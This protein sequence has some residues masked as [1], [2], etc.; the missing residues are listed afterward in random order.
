MC[1]VA[2]NLVSFNTRQ[3]I[4]RS[5]GRA[6]NVGYDAE[7]V[8]LEWIDDVPGFPNHE[9]TLLENLTDSSKHVK[10]KLDEKEK[11]VI[12]IISQW[13]RFFIW[14]TELFLVHSQRIPEFLKVSFLPDEIVNEWKLRQD[15][16]NHIPVKQPSGIGRLWNRFE[17]FSHVGFR[18]EQLVCGL[19]SPVGNPITK[20]LV[21]ENPPWIQKISGDKVEAM[22]HAPDR[23]K[24]VE[25]DVG[26]RA[27]L[28]D[29]LFQCRCHSTQSS[30]HISSSVG[31][32]WYKLFKLHS[33]FKKL[34][35]HQLGDSVSC[36]GAQNF[37][38]QR[39][40]DNSVFKRE[41][42][43]T[44]EQVLAPYQRGVNCN[45]I[46]TTI[47]HIALTHLFS[48][49]FVS[50]CLPHAWIVTCLDLFC[51]CHTWLVNKHHHCFPER[52]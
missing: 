39:C 29:Q 24:L 25:R 35:E 22:S 28:L 18:E 43:E 26:V 21:H 11:T 9:V 42:D 23:V 30:N 4:E 10:N 47:L 3:E 46:E 37:K 2:F 5:W 40:L 34:V 51:N 48:F 49:L 6:T 44:G 36:W 8:F 12:F 1:R 52:K 20:G 41:T 38:E 32:N 27:V 33:M 31:R 14:Q 7:N 17:M 15:G 45:G 16:R 13:K 50:E 19:S